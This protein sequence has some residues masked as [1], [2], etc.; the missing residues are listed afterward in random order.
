MRWRSD[1]SRLLSSVLAPVRRS[2]A[3][4]R[5]KYQTSISYP[6]SR[7]PS[8]WSSNGSGPVK[9]KCLPPSDQ[10]HC[11]GPFWILTEYWVLSRVLFSMNSFRRFT[12]LVTWNRRFEEVRLPRACICGLNSWKRKGR[13][14]Y[15]SHTRTVST[16]MRHI[17]TILSKSSST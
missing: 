1:R 16:S 8:H 12:T 14:I 2:R 7:I 15:R 4:P 9:Q 11:H 5:S 13:A 17:L 10:P 3:Q 6:P